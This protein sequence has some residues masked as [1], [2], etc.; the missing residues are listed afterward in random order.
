MDDTENL[1]FDE[2]LL[3][4]DSSW[5]CEGCAPPIFDLPPP[6]RP[7]WLEDLEDCD[8]KPS[9]SDV[10]SQLETCD[11]T[12]I[13]DHQTLFDDTFHSIA[14]IVVSAIVLVVILLVGAVMIFR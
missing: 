1:F 7:P 9:I 5:D 13:R 6:P 11:S 8:S 3:F 10:L 12:V 2:S 4:G 14:V